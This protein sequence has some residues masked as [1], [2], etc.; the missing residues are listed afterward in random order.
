MD[1]ARITQFKD[2]RNKIVHALKYLEV[3]DFNELNWGPVDH[4]IQHFQ[5]VAKF[6]DEIILRLFGLGRYVDNPYKGM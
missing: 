4:T 1:D 6:V 2:V 5:V 3:T